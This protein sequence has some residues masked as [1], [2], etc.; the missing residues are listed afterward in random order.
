MLIN[1]TDARKRLLQNLKWKFLIRSTAIYL[2]LF[3][4]TSLATSLLTWAW[5]C[6]TKHSRHRKDRTGIVT[7]D[8]F[9]LRLTQKANIKYSVLKK[10]LPIHLLIVGIYSEEAAKTGTHI[11]DWVTSRSGSAMQIP[12]NLL[13][14]KGSESLS[15]S[16]F[17]LKTTHCVNVW[18]EKRTH[19]R[20]D[21]LN[22]KYI[23]YYSVNSIAWYASSIVDGCHNLLL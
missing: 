17:T 19:M 13:H 21:D 4:S 11:Y 7:T 6:P 15:G 10:E 9:M 23:I 12:L 16:T 5:L 3:M 1:R 14:W 8:I 18:T 20:F 22:H 2:Q